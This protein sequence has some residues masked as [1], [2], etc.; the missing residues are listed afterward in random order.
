MDPMLITTLATSATAFL[1]PY[2]AK[3]GEAAA[4]ALGEKV[5]EA[6][7]KVWNAITAKFKG[8]PVAEAVAKEL[9][10]KPED[11]G[12]QEMFQLQLKQVL[13]ADKAFAEELKQLLESAGRA[14]G[15]TNISNTG[16][17]AVAT[18]GGVA[19]GEGGAAVGGNVLGDITVGGSKKKS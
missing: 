3:A 1:A 14:M 19:A 18:S 11:K 5:P 13:E 15:Q 8:K 16:S 17:G 9:E 4:E 6:A 7:G 12:A 2:L 10:T